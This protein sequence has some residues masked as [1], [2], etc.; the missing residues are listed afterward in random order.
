MCWGNETA[1]NSTFEFHGAITALDTTSQTLTVRGIHVSY[2]AA[3]Q[4]AG[5]TIAQLAV[6]QNI[7]V[8]GTLATDRTSVNAVTISFN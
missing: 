4:F 1:A 2:A 7:A 6:G 8:V 5:G 3:V